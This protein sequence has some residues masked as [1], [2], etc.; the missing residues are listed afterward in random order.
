MME[1]I[2]LV[3]I[4]V[5]VLISM[6]V[7][8]RRGIQGMVKVVADQVGNQQDADQKFDDTGHLIGSNTW[9]SSASIK[10]ERQEYDIMNYIFNDRVIS[11]STQVANLGFTQRERN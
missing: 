5:I 10:E 6:N 3:G 11:T 8:I 2:S 4:V 9:T 1:Y 7:F